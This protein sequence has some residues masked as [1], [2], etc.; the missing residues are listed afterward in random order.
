METDNSK[1]VGNS[2]RHELKALSFAILLFT[3]VEP[4]PQALD[5]C[6][7]VFLGNRT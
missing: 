5:H 6:F 3:A 7:S 4:L 2:M 1:L